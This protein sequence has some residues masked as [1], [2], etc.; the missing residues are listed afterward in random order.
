MC[1]KTIAFLRDVQPWEHN[2][3][4]L[5]LPNRFWL[6]YE[7]TDK[8]EDFTKVEDLIPADLEFRIASELKLIEPKDYA[9]FCSVVH[10]Y[11]ASIPGLDK[12]TDVGEELMLLLQGMS[13][14]L[15]TAIDGLPEPDK[16]IESIDK[17]NV[18]KY[19]LYTSL[20]SGTGFLLLAACA[21]AGFAIG[22]IKIGE[23]SEKFTQYKSLWY[24]AA[25]VGSAVGAWA[26]GF[27]SATIIYPLFSKIE[28]YLEKKM[29]KQ[30][31]Q[32]DDKVLEQLTKQV[33]EYVS[34]YP[35]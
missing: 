24:V 3:K 33:N 2:F 7:S 12:Q 11:V 27:G 25:G 30:Q 6:F 15:E 1:P 13:K 14:R 21:V 31:G 20:T 22:G 23:L 10:D 32:V 17:T 16:V 19:E 34:R 4:R 5:E 35:A 18:K 29:N 8:P 26:G 9:G 28:N